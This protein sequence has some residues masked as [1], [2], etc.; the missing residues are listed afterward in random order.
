MIEQEAR[1]E[2]VEG[3]EAVVVVARQSACGACSAKS[4]CGTALVGSIFPSRQLV[5]RMPNSQHAMPGERIVVGLP[6][7]SLQLAAL[8]LYGLPLLALLAGALTGQAIAE[9]SVWPTEPAAIVGGLF[10]LLVG[11]T[12]T[13]RLGAM[14]SG[15]R[16]VMLRR[17]PAGEP[18]FVGLDTLQAHQTNVS[19]K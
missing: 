8:L 19:E 1:V 13:R 16:P 7:G 2:A 6:E 9:S 11:L 10:G 5:L 4:G 12:A 3:D 18:W 15:I 17:L 14:T